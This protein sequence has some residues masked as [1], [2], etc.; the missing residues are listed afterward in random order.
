M[1]RPVVLIHGALRTRLGLWPTARMLA[2]A[3][4]APH[5][6]GYPTRRGTLADHGARLSAFLE[7]RGLWAPSDVPLG[8]VTHSMGALVARAFLARASRDRPLPRPVRLVML[9]PPNRGARLAARLADA[10]YARWLYGDAL[11]QL[12]PDV[13]GRLGPLPDGAA[14]L[15]LASGTGGPK[16][17]NPLLDGDDDGVVA[18]ADMPLEGAAWAFVGGMHPWLQWRPAVVRRAAAFLAGGAEHGAVPGGG[19]EPPT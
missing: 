6:F 11:G 12:H 1:T 13:A 17:R 3:G 15:V 4:F 2:R 18:V 8:I 9:A 14:G 19:L 7:A 16:G 10:P 5:R